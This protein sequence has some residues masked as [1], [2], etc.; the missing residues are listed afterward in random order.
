[1]AEAHGNSHRSSEVFESTRNSNLFGYNRFIT[2]VLGD[3][4]IASETY[5]NPAKANL[6]RELET[7][8][9]E[10]AIGLEKAPELL[11]EKANAKNVLELNQY[12]DNQLLKIARLRL[13][14]EP[15]FVT[16][17]QVHT[18]TQR[19]YIILRAL[20]LDEHMRKIK[21]FSVSLGSSES[22]EMIDS[23]LVDKEKYN[24]SQMLANLYKESY[25]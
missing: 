11:I 24:L 4:D 15:E 10:L 7:L 3:P 1:M 18:Q 23:N 14:I 6:L 2:K 5:K 9:S 22:L 25:P 19:S 17:K 21:K 8:V 16:N 20:W 12:I 13:V